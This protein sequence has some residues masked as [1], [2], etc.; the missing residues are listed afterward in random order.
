MLAVGEHL[1]GTVDEQTMRMTTGFSGGIGS[2]HGELCGALSAG[3]MLIGALHGRT[4]T[5][6]D[7]RVCLELSARYR[8][9]FVQ[10]FGSSTCQA[11][12]DRYANCPWLVEKASRILL[13]IIDEDNL[14]GCP[15]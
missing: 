1:L 2:T 9:G 15:Q 7:D 10:E 3:V 11:L 4:R 5:G 12:R 13:D 14:E 8:N 6:V